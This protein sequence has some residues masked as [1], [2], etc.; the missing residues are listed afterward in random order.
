MTRS[1]LGLDDI[2]QEIIFL[3]KKIHNDTKIIPLTSGFEIC[4][5]TCPDQVGS[6]LMK[7]LMQVISITAGQLFW[8]RNGFWFYCG[9][10]WKLHGTHQAVHST[11]ADTNAIVTT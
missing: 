3:E 5:I 8:A 7:G 10:R 1:A 11:D 9:H 6:F 4:K 2:F